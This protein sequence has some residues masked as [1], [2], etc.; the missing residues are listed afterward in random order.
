MI[1]YGPDGAP[2]PSPFPATQPIPLPAHLHPSVELDALP[3]WVPL[4]VLGAA[5]ALVVGI[6]VVGVAG[7]DVIA[8]W[9]VA[10]R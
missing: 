2:L 10:A 1:T 7:W 3:W 4:A 8:A 6:A 9:A 5:L